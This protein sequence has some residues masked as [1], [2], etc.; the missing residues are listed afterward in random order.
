MGRVGRDPHS[1]TSVPLVRNSPN[2][3]ETTCGPRRFPHRA[4]RQANMVRISTGR[5]AKA[6]AAAATGSPSRH[7]VTKR[8]AT[9]AAQRETTRANR[10]LTL[11]SSSPRSRSYSTARPCV[12][13]TVAHSAGHPM[14]CRYRSSRYGYLCD[15]PGRHQ[16]PVRARSSKRRAAKQEASRTAAP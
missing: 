2:L 14:W 12:F 9:V 8:A 10:R 1:R 11:P 4:A 15:L 7:M 13:A 6:N 3:L 16:E 5:S